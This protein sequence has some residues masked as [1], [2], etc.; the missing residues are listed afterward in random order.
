MK[1]Q[2][3]TDPI[4]PAVTR[5]FLAAVMTAGLG[6]SAVAAVAAPPGDAPFGAYDPDGDFSE[7]SDLLIE[8]LFLPWEDVFLPS[9]A[10]ADSY[11]L[12]RDRALLVTLEPWTWS[13]DERNT[14]QYLLAGIE[15]GIYDDNMRVICEAL[16]TLESPVTL[17][18]AHEMDDDRGQFIWASW[19]PEQYIGAYRRMIDVCRDSAPDVTFMWSPLGDE[20]MEAFYPGDDYVDLVGITVFGLQAWD[21]A[22]YGRDRRFEDIFAPRYERAATFGKPVVVAELG[23][24]GRAD[25]IESWENAVRQPEGD[26]PALAGVVYFNYPEVHSWPDG[27][28]RP[29]WRI[30]RRTLD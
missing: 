12:E 15:G 24:V 10:D 28:G 29:D 27:F 16:D 5:R 17:R 18:W 7:D 2:P 30:G 13:R 21:Q 6:L 20:G 3:E 4:V 25:Y 1:P 23:Y 9:L 19:T 11:A 22:K 14:P 26:Y 8:H